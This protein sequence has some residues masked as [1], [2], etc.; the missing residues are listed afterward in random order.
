MCK[1]EEIITILWGCLEIEKWWVEVG[2]G[3]EGYKKVKIN[4]R[5]RVER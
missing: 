2:F 3:E 1:I 5:M 4:K